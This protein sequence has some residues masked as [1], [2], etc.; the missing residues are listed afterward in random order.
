MRS[1]ALALSAAILTAAAAISA[2]AEVTPAKYFFY[3][4]VTASQTASV[5]PG[6]V[7]PISV[8]VDTSFPAFTQVNHVTTYKIGAGFNGPAPILKAT[9]NGVDVTGLGRSIAITQNL[10]GVYSIE[11][12]TYSPQ[13][14]GNLDILLKTSVAGVVKGDRIPKQVFPGNFTIQ[15]FSTT[16]GFDD[17]FSGQI[18]D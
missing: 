16:Y 11:I 1:P 3:G 15:T 13:G 7:V 10:N 14:S 9:I 18:I 5:P 2:H 17:G 6:T 8:T 12:I 4:L